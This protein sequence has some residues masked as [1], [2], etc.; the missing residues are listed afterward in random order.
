[1]LFILCQ[2]NSKSHKEIFQVIL[3]FRPFEVLEQL[4]QDESVNTVESDIRVFN[5]S[6]L[7]GWYN[8]VISVSLICFGLFAFIDNWLDFFCLMQGRSQ[9]S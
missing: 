3:N 9:R 4:K 5:S 7:V 1:M 2:N 8:F 6:K